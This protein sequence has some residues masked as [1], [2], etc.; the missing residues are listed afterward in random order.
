M[1]GAAALPVDISGAAYLPPPLGAGSQV[2]Q[3]AGVRGAVTALRLEGTA[4]SVK[5]RLARLRAAFPEREML[6]LHS[7][8]SQVFWREVRDVTP[9]AGQSDRVIW[10]LSVAPGE[11]HRGFSKAS[12]PR[13]PGNTSSTGQAGCS[14]W[15]CPVLMPAVR[16]MVAPGVSGMSRPGTADTRRWWWRPVP[17][18]RAVDPFQP[19]SPGLAAL[20][21]RIKTAF[22]PK[23]ILN[24]GRLYREV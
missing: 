12:V 11:T 2:A 18:R 9:L 16:R 7:R 8:N 19:L 13:S 17:L 24:P 20:T 3:V 10:R 4:A 6:D 21:G 5:V 23:G 22:D 14:G 15:R 1:A